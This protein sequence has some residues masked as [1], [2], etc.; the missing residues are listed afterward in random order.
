MKGGKQVLNGKV[1]LCYSGNSRRGAA[2]RCRSLACLRPCQGVKL[3]QEGEIPRRCCS[4]CNREATAMRLGF[5]HPSMDGASGSTGRGI[6]ACLDLR[7]HRAQLGPRRRRQ[8]RRQDRN[9]REDGRV[10]QLQKR[11]RCRVRQRQDNPHPVC[12]NRPQW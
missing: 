2:Q 10:V 6:K 5:C 3:A 12:E 9:C 11:V 7:Q 1:G 4:A 8:P